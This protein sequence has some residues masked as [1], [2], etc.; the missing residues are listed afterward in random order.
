VW[1]SYFLDHGSCINRGKQKK[2]N[3]N[4][5]KSINDKNLNNKLFWKYY[6]PKLRLQF[7][8]LNQGFEESKTNSFHFWYDMI[9]Q[10]TFRD[11][12]QIPGTKLTAK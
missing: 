12:F 8:S 11:S 6:I 9:Y 3:I 2:I 10:L 5:V 1:D 7:D 4:I